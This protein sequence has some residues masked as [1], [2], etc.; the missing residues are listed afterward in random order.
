MTITGTV[1]ADFLQA[2]TIAIV[3]EVSVRRLRHAIPAFSTRSE[4][5][6]YLFNALGIEASI[7]HLSGHG[8]WTGRLTSERVPRGGGARDPFGASRT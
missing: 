2:A 1:V 3:G 5:W 8:G 4:I 7:R 6:L